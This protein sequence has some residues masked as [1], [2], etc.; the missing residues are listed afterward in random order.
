MNPYGY[1]EPVWRLFC[2]APKAGVLD[3][4]NVIRVQAGDPARQ[5]QLELQVRMEGPVIAAARFRALG[6]PS[7]IA[8]GAWLAGE[9]QGRSLNGLPTMTAAAIREGLQLA[10]DRAHCALLGEDAVLLLEKALK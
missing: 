4:E 3:G 9:L 8:V 1:P 5:A 2:E 6:C 10:E 7:T